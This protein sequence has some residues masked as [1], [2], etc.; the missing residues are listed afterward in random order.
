MDG[1]KNVGLIG[2]LLLCLAVPS[3]AMSLDELYVNEG[4]EYI[5]LNFAENKFLTFGGNLYDGQSRTMYFEG[6][7]KLEAYTVVLQISSLYD[8]P[9][10]TSDYLER[11]CL[12]DPFNGTPQIVNL[13]SVFWGQQ[14]WIT[15]G[16]TF[17][18]VDIPQQPEFESEVF[19]N[20][21]STFWFTACNLTMHGTDV[22]LL[23][24]IIPTTNSIDNFATPNQDLADFVGNSSTAGVRGIVN[25]GFDIVGMQLIICC[26]LILAFLLIYTAKLFEWFAEHIK[27][28]NE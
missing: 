11:S 14:Y 5:G 26:L 21:T 18:Q 17:M 9:G 28:N 16:Y 24:Y 2:L 27:V 1:Y 25:V 10:S 3:V 23:A 4:G 8:E 22:K 15:K 6:F 20:I 12:G 19:G 13:T 7:N